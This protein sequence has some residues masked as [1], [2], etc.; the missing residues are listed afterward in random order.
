MV[1]D[2]HKNDR[3]Q[4]Y[5]SYIL[6]C[7]YKER[8]NINAF[9]NIKTY[10]HSLTG[11]EFPARITTWILATMQEQKSRNQLLLLVLLPRQRSDEFIINHNFRFLSHYKLDWI[12]L[13]TFYYISASAS[14]SVRCLQGCRWLSSG[15]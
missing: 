4:T 7:L 1:T 10:S 11:R 8:T 13:Q 12:S 3:T 6:F 15:L 5:H 14:F 9:L 2:R